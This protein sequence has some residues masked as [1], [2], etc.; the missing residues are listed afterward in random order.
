MDVD[1]LTQELW[2]D[3][4]AEVAFYRVYRTRDQY[5]RDNEQDFLVGTYLVKHDYSRARG[6]KA[7]QG[8]TDA[9]PA[10]KYALFYEFE[11]RSYEYK[12]S[13]VINAAQADL[14]PLKA[15]FASFDWCA[16]QYRE[17]AFSGDGLVQ[18]LYRS[19]D[20][21]NATDQWRHPGT[22]Y[23]AS[24]IPLLV[25]ALTGNSEFKVLQEDGSVVSVSA[26]LSRD[27]RGERVDLTYG[28]PVLSLVGEESALTESWW[29]GTGPDRLLVAMEAGD[30]RYG[31]ELVEHLRSA[32]WEE[33]LYTRLQTVTERP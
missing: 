4:Q 10:F 30:G 16:N 28:A 31:L 15:S 17:Y 7:V 25:R 6:S 23:P 26:S 22:V 19:D 8:D 27:E 33:D 14:S 20:Y 24:A 18:H 11:S 21:G 2:N 9:V 13:W 29:R 5:G 1:W 12:R 32:Y 3:G